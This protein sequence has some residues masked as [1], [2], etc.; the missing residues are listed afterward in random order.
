MIQDIVI[1]VFICNANSTADGFR[2]RRAMADDAAAIHTQKRC[3]TIFR[4]IQTL[5]ELLEC[6]HYQQC[7]QL[8]EEAA[9]LDRFL[10]E[11][12]QSF[13]KALCKF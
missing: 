13:R 7:A 8:R 10:N 1:H 3:A 5:A 11:L 6:R 9:I 4:H 12:H 2:I